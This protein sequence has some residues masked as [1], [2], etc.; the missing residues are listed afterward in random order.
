MKPVAQQMSMAHR[1]QDPF[2]TCGSISLLTF[3]LSFS[4]LFS[5]KTALCH[6][7]GFHTS[8]PLYIL[9]DLPLV[10]GWKKKQ[11]ESTACSSLTKSTN[12]FASVPTYSD[13]LPVKMD[14]SLLYL[15]WRL[16]AC[17]LHHLL[18]EMAPQCPGFPASV[19]FSLFCRVIPV[20]VP[21]YPNAS[22]Q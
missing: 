10:S 19:P 16:P 2:S 9:N 21:I 17:A 1:K 3:L 8:T 20:R 22:L 18:K 5:D 11:P 6:I 12:C 15:M 4:L 7:L 13:V 14:E